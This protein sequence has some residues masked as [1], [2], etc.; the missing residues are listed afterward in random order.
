MIGKR[1]YQS[2]FELRARRLRRRPA[3]EFIERRVVLSS[4]TV[5]TVADSTGA[6]TLR[7]AIEQ[8]NAGPG[9]GSISFDIPGGGVQV[10]ALEQPLP[11]I[12]NPVVIDGTTQ[13]G[14]SGSPLIQIEPGAI[15][16]AGNNGL[17]LSAASNTIA[18]LSIVGFTGSGI[19]L[20]PAANATEMVANYIGWSAAGGQA[21]PNGT[22]I[23]I[24]GASNNTIG[25][26][27]A[28]SG[29]VISGNSVD[30][31]LINTGGG[32][33]SDNDI[34]GN[35]IGSDPTGT[36]ADG[37]GQSGIDL[38]AAPG[39][40]IGLPLTGSG[41]V[42]S[43]NT[44]PGIELLSGATGTVIQ[45]NE[46][47]FA[48][49]G[50]SALG[51]GGDGIYLS[52]SPWNQIGGTAQID[53]NLIGSNDGNGINA[54]GSASN[55]L[56]EGNF[57]GTDVTGTLNR[58]NQSNGIELGSSSN[59][60]G[61][62]IAG[63]ANTI[64]FNGAG[65]PGSGVQ[66]VGSPTFNEILSN[67]IYENSVLGIN[68]GNGPTANHQPGTPGPNNYQNYPTLL[69]AQGD[70]TQ[71]TIQGKLIGLPSTNYVIQFFCNATPSASGFGQGQTLIGSDVVPTNGNGLATFAVPIS[72]D[73][74]PGEWISATA[75][76]PAG[77]TSEFAA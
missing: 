66:L 31:I 47:G 13:P 20:N 29:N 59:T 35:L 75:T 62:T 73:T 23:S 39:T 40:Q 17:V 54:Q 10:I 32:A 55:T 64:D 77:D 61:G 7:W 34:Y 37:T 30:G 52:D 70:G 43:G 33:G 21:S 74:A 65:Q 71:T 58:G 26:T 41:N 22:G 18:G 69:A 50:K 53:A 48:L 24:N 3:C 19:V 28:G 36:F 44:G 51:N 49:N 11:A 76:D 15:R 2:R 67:S 68:L 12:T 63:A 56:V 1:R 72:A 14:Y 25:G 42:I 57:I 4:F 9:A 16:Q 46:I 38:V 27:S 6:N 5:T 60:I 45:N 8:V